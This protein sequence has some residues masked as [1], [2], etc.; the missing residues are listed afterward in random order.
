MNF[1][2]RFLD[3]LR[4]RVVLSEIVGQKVRLAK[5]GREFSGLCPF[6][7]E[8]TPSF[9]LNDDKGFYHCFGCGAHGDA[10]SFL[11]EHDKMPFTEAVEYLAARVGLVKRIA[12]P[13]A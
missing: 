1:P 7:R 13:M 8:K 6:H 12:K 2:P 9:T 10:L 5:K 4:D 3:E 11:M